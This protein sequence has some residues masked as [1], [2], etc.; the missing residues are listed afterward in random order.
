[1][2]GFRD[3][4]VVAEWAVA[5]QFRSLAKQFSEFEN[6]VFAQKA[7]DV[8]DLDRRVLSHLMG[9]TTSRLASLHEPVIIVAHELT[10][11]QTASMDR[12]KVLGFATDAG[13]RTS[14]VSIRC[15]CRRH[16]GCRRLPSHQP[17]RRGRAT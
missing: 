1:M 12:S 2:L 3:D 13:G 9:E 4:L 16:S 8:I 10:P 7:N 14:H 5:D 15:P 17:P 11:S 6:E